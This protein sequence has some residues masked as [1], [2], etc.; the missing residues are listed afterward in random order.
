MGKGFTAAAPGKTER[1][2][3]EKQVRAA[4]DGRSLRAKGRTAQLNVKVAPE[5]KQALN[6]HCEREGVSVADWMEGT[7]RAALGLGEG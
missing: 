1:K 3:P 5:L 7:L 4:A 2:Q 6:A